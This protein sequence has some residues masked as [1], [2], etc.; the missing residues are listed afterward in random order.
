MDPHKSKYLKYK[1]KYVTLKNLIGGNCYN[2]NCNETV[3][4]GGTCCNGVTHTS[5]R[6]HDGFRCPGC[7]CKIRQ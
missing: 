4:L 1:Q 2:P 5:Q 6:S 7:G 3:N